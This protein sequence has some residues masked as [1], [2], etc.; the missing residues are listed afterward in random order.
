[1]IINATALWMF[2][3]CPRPPSTANTDSIL[4]TTLRLLHN[5]SRG[6]VSGSV[7]FYC[8]SRLLHS[9][10]LMGGFV[11]FIGNNFELVVIGFPFNA[12]FP[13]IYCDFMNE[14]GGRMKRVN[15]LFRCWLCWFVWW[16]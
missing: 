3:G 16:Q 11:S 15:Q 8:S 7:R 6:Q 12:F 2:A 13:L 10:G 1:M 14:R 9:L 4:M 5:L